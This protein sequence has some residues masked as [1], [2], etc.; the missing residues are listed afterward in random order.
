MNDLAPFKPLA[1]PG[2]P[3]LIAAFLA[4]RCQK[5]LETYRQC[6]DDFTRF[7]GA[8]TIDA[9]ARFFLAHAPGEANGLVLAYRTQLIE[10]GL[11]ANTIN[12]RLAAVRSLVK[13]ARTLGLV[14][15]SIEIA[16][17][18]AEPY[19][20]TRGPG[21]AGFRSL[22]AA[23]AARSDAKG[24]RDT[25]ILR[26]LFDLALRR[27]EVTRLDAADFDDA[28]ATLAVRGKGKSHKQTLTLPAPTLEALRR[29]IADRGPAPGPLFLHLAGGR[30]VPDAPGPQDRITGHSLYRLVKA[31]GDSAGLRARPH[32]LRHAAITEALDLTGGNVRA[33]QKFSRHA[34]VRI[35]AVY[36]DN[37]QDLAGDVAKLVSSVAR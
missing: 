1:L 27:C 18:P 32:G 25:A 36:D 10:R 23:L 29:W 35:L 4:G 11:A 14:Q 33:V 9:A 12:L 15:W 26:L 7:V 37:R 3:D 13:L 31:L 21:A 17:V 30:R 24:R 19:R 28:A 34:D 22:L 8:E 2:P 16:N 5:T 6:L 20:D